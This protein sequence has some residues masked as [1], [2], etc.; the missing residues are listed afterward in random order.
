MMA[1]FSGGTNEKRRRI[2]HGEESGV[3]SC[4]FRGRRQWPQAISDVLLL[5]RG[6][7]ALF[8]LVFVG[9]DAL[10]CIFLLGL[11]GQDAMSVIFLLA[12]VGQDARSAIFLL[13]FGSQGAMG[14]LFL[15]LL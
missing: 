13:V 1:T 7:G 5:R 2:P 11:V 3:P 10:S 14:A 12:F 4:F 15:F 9:Q 8:L 6:C